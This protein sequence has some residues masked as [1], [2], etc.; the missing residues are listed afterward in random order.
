MLRLQPASPSSVLRHEYGDGHVTHSLAG[1]VRG[2]KLLATNVVLDPRRMKN[3]RTPATIPR[4]ITGSVQ[5][6]LML[7]RPSSASHTP[8]FSWVTRGAPTTAR[9]TRSYASCSSSRCRAPAP[10]PRPRT[11]EVICAVRAPPARA[12]RAKRWP[13]SSGRTSRSESRAGGASRSSR[14]SR[15]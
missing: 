2:L 8:A 4:M 10:T 13:T 14:A 3:K 12:A 9:W 15:P 6:L 7:Q 11:S 5:S 1:I